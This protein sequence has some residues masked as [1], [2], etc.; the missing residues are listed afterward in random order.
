MTDKSSIF[1][2]F[3]VRPKV[4]A[5]LAGIGLT[6]LYDRLNS[7]EYESFVDGS[8]RMVTVRSIKAR[9]ERLLAAASGTPRDKPSKRGGGP[10]RPKRN[11]AT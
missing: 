7:G 9:Q 4:A 1:E 10:G 5:Q 8:T 11:A 2:P 6:T 3:A